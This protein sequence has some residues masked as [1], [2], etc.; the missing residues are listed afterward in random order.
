MREADFWLMAFSL[1]LSV[2]VIINA[3]DFLGSRC[4]FKYPKPEARIHKLTLWGEELTS[5]AGNSRLL[6]RKSLLNL[7]KEF[8]G[9]TGVEILS[10]RG[11]TKS[12]SLAERIRLLTALLSRCGLRSGFKLFILYEGG[13]REYPQ[14]EPSLSLVKKVI[15]GLKVVEKCH[16]RS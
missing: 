11:Y 14:E 4:C 2:Y 7:G 12:L 13:L 1:G 3:V 6:L 8:E 5:L 10:E 9:L 15:D 16:Q